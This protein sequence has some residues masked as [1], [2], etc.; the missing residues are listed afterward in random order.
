MMNF[1]KY[2]ALLTWT[3]TLSGCEIKLGHPELLWLLWAIPVLIGFYVYTFRNRSRL[4]EQFASLQMLQ[5]IASGVSPQRQQLKAGLII[6][7]F[8][9][10]IFTLTEPKWGFTW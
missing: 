7:G 9:L 8:S 1:V 5:R 4:L 6:V 3:L 10:L 2:L